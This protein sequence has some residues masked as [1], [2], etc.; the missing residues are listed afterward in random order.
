M[1]FNLIIGRHNTSGRSSYKPWRRGRG[2]IVKQHLKGIKTNK[3]QT[4]LHRHVTVQSGCNFVLRLK[5]NERVGVVNGLP[6][7][8]SV[9]GSPDQGEFCVFLKV[10]KR[11]V[12]MLHRER[13]PL[14]KSPV[15][16]GFLFLM[17]ASND[18]E[19]QTDSKLQNLA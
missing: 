19:V 15:K 4:A 14:F 9:V 12:G 8:G 1:D 3:W 16:R 11:N 13:F 5:Q 17:A 7:F 10:F 6:K 18:L 2:N